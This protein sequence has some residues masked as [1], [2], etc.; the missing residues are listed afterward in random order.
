M[1]EEE[2]KAESRGGQGIGHNSKRERE[3]ILSWPSL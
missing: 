3:T 2:E 1:G